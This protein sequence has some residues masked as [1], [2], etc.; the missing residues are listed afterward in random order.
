[1]A[2]GATAA[3]TGGASGCVVASPGRR[4]REDRFPVLASSGAIREH[5]L[6]DRPTEDV[7][8]FADSAT[9][10]EQLQAALLRGELAI[11]RQDDAGFE[12]VTFAEQLSQVAR[13]EG[14]DVA[15]YDVG[16]VALDG[17]K[18][19]LL[20]RADRGGRSGTGAPPPGSRPP[21]GRSES[22]STPRTLVRAR[23]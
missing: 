13:Y 12:E 7:D 18:A 20:G 15:E 23:R 6:T 19:R 22:L 5:G 21:R 4:V 17:A 3:V 9:S 11:A 1:M 8:L 10:S 14:S 16:P 2:P